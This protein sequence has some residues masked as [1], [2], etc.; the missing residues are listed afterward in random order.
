MSDSDQ[1]LTQITTQVTNYAQTYDNRFEIK[2]LV[3]PSDL[4]SSDNRYGGNYIMFRVMIHEDSYLNKT[5]ETLTGVQSNTTESQKASL[6]GTVSDTTANALFAVTGG[7]AGLGVGSQVSNSLPGKLVGGGLGAAAA[8]KVREDTFGNVKKSYKTQKNAIC[9][10][11]PNDLMVK[12]G[13]SWEESNFATSALLLTAAN[14]IVDSALKNNDGTFSI[15]NIKKMFEGV[16]VNKL[17]SSAPALVLRTPGTGDIISKLSG[18]AANPKKEQLFKQVDFRTFTFSYQ[19]FPRDLKEAQSVQNIIKE[20]K[21]HMHPE[22]R[23]AN[24]FIYIYPSEFEIIYFSGGKE[25]LNIHRHTACALT[26]MNISYAP[27]G[28]F[29]AFENGIPTQINITLTFKE[30]ALLTKKDIEAG[31]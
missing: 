10:Y 6:D 4:L 15:D 3:Y 20:F 14:S 1:T 29:T 30:L 19:F 9:L 22:F 21:L 24:Q 16:D 27:Q 18:T 2:G 7:I 8:E 25:N 11:M 12:Y 5:R 17:E 28:V 23:D 13:V 31:F 26:D